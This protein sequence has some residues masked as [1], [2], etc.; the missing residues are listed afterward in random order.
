[1]HIFEIGRAGALRVF[2]H[3]LMPELVA[4]E[5]RGLGIEPL[6]LGIAGLQVAVEGIERGQW[7]SVSSA[8]DQLLI[9]PA[10][11]QVFALAQANQ[12]QTPVL[13]DDLALRRRLEKEMNLVVGTVGLL[14]RAYKV[15]Y[16]RRDELESAVDALFVSST[17][18]MSRAFRAYVRQLLIGVE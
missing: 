1:M 6:N 4:E 11:A 15:G 10:D 2:D 17:L 16:L 5:L 13:T 9:H 8:P 3:L 18:H 7:E 14:L 12:F